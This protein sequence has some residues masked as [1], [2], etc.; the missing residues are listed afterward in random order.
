MK[1]MLFYGFGVSLAYLL[2]EGSS[3]LGLIFVRSAKP[4]YLSTSIEKHFSVLDDDDLK[5]YLTSRYHPVLGWDYR[6][7]ERVE[8]RNCLGEAWTDSHNPDGSRVNPLQFGSTLVATY[9][10]SF[11]LGAEV[12][13]NGT[14]QYFLTESLES[15]TKNFGV[16]GYG[17]LQA[18]MKLKLHISEGRIFP[19]IILGVHES[20]LRRAVNVFRP[21]VSPQTGGKLTFK[22]AIRCFEDD[23]HIIENALKPGV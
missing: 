17:I 20:N 10:D 13:D 12:Q 23:C 21:F 9:G 1:K 11:T 15:G 5:R 6:P 22:P 18:L 7:H 8:D 3:F 16:G 2:L 14:W 19:V 4:H